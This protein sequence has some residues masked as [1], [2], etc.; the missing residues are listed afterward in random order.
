MIVKKQRE[1]GA[2]KSGGDSAD[3]CQEWRATVCDGLQTLQ[4]DAVTEVSLNERSNLEAARV[5]LLKAIHEI[6]PRK[7]RTPSP[8]TQAH[9]PRRRA[10]YVGNHYSS[11]W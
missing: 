4:R 6:K 3:K 5:V 9:S 1:D 11:P 8:T 10:P 7:T 2:T